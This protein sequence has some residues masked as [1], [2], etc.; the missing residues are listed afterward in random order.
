M[1]EG[2]VGRRVW[3]EWEEDRGCVRETPLLSAPLPRCQGGD[4]LDLKSKT[5]VALL[6]AWL[7]QESILCCLLKSV[8]CLS[9]LPPFLFFPSSLNKSEAYSEAARCVH[10]NKLNLPICMAC[11]VLK[12]PAV[13]C[14]R[15]SLPS[16][17]S[18]FPS[19]LSTE[20][21]TS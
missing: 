20:Y 2:C 4:V 5:C 18:Q 6:C 21:S 16:C 19:S 10:A 8:L 11:V 9:P 17:P 12:Y 7:V 3:N 1:G 15:V 13:C 14:S